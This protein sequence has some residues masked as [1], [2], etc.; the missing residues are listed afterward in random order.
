M[1]YRPEKADEVL[2]KVFDKYILGKHSMMQ[3]IHRSDP[4]SLMFEAN[5]KRVINPEHAAVTHVCAAKHRIESIFKPRS[6]FVIF[7]DAVI[8]PAEEIIASL[9]GRDTEDADSFG[10]TRPE[11][12]LAH[13]DDERHG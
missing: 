13:C 3:K 5:V 7:I 9:T 10:T 1:V 11:R 6:R 2:A 8:A 4:I 12:V